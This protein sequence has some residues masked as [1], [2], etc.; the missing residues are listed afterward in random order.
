[1]KAPPRSNWASR[2]RAAP[3]LGVT[4]QPMATKIK[5]TGSGS[6][7]V[8]RQPTSVSRPPMTSPNEYPLAAQKMQ[9]PNARLRVGSRV[10]AW[11][12]ALRVGGAPR[13]G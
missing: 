9:I 10:A 12:G 11:R 4:F 8:A 2:T 13:R 1:M 3:A 7:S 5:A 6:R